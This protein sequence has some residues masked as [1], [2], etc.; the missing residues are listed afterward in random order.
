ML[1]TLPLSVVGV[2]ARYSVEK[3]REHEFNRYHV[4]QQRHVLIIQG[5]GSILCTRR[6]LDERDFQRH[7]GISKDVNERIE[8]IYF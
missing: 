8:S 3:I 1:E 5:G 6:G 2:T 4:Q 7:D